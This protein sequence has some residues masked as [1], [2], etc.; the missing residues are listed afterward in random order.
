MQF[1]G[2]MVEPQVLVL[3]IVYLSEDDSHTTTE[4]TSDLGAL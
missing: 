1:S 2:R 4:I 3:E